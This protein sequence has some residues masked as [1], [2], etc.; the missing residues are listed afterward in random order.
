M[1]FFGG[2][3]NAISSG[4][5]AVCS[6]GSSICTGL[7]KVGIYLGGAIGKGLESLSKFIMRMPEIDI[8]DVIDIISI[9]VSEIGEILGISEDDS[10]EEI[11][12][13]SLQADKKP[14]DFDSIEQYIAY[15]EKEIEL[16]KIKFKEMSQEQKLTCNAIGSIIV[17]K[18]ISENK[19]IEVG[20]DF[21]V[22]AA[23]QKMQPREAEIYIDRFKE[24]N[25][26]LKLSDYLKCNL[27]LEE[28]R[29]IDPVVKGVIK[30]L[31]PMF[32]EEEID[33]KL[34]DMT[35]KSLENE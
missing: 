16:D 30:E 9:I 25:L 34:D 21:L 35:N 8:I 12:F 19:G 23:K 1:S 13:K 17:A 32:T 18:G 29:R 20:V 26:E 10:T 6:L 24:N 14:E 22:E 2:I 3:A 31:N 15:L 33:T 4:I 7:Y 5:N 27:P 28:V 11:G